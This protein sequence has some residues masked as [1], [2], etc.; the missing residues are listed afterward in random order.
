MREELSNPRFIQD[1]I[2]ID[3]DKIGEREIMSAERDFPRRG[4]EHES[5]M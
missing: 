3:V 5:L 4:P 1:C 2:N